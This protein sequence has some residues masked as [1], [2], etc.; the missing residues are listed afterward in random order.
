LTQNQN[1]EARFHRDIKEYVLLSLRKAN[2]MTVKI[3]TSILIDEDIWENFKAKASSNKGLKG[4]SKAVEE[5]LEE[6]LSEK[7]VTQVLENMYS[8]KPTELQV[9]PIKPKIAT[10]AGKVIRELREQP[11]ENLP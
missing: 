6:E 3:K 2:N 9:T 8:R 5:A 7:I 4:I 10:S 1:L 11:L